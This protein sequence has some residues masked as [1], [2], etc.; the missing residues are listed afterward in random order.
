MN[1]KYIFQNVRDWFLSTFIFI[2]ITYGSATIYDD[3]L[4]IG[5][6]FSH[7]MKPGRRGQF[8]G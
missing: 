5:Y 4:S 8:S 7:Q 3:I 1:I 2:S 6:C